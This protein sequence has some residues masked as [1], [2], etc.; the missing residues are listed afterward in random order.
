MILK[1]FYGNTAAT[2]NDC[3]GTAHEN[4]VYISPPGGCSDCAI[5]DNVIYG[6]I[7]EPLYITLEQVDAGA[8]LTLKIYNNVMYNITPAHGGLEIDP[9]QTS[10]GTRGTI[11]FYNN[12]IEMDS[13]GEGVRVASRSNSCLSQLIARNNHLI[14]SSTALIR[15]ESGGCTRITQDHNVSQTPSAASSQGY[16]SANMYAPTASGNATVNA[17]MDGSSTVP[18]VD[19]LGV[20]RPAGGA[21]DAGAYER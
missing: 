16:T 8:P 7:V 11:Y 18:A 10:D 4:N 3:T 17:G 5:Y 20:T 14:S 1:Y 2:T 15:D 12:T 6:N 21:W 9:E 13:G 19:R